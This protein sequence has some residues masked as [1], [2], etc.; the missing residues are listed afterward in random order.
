M[1]FK[2]FLLFLLKCIYVYGAHVFGSPW[3]PEEGAGVPGGA[4]NQAQVLQ[5]SSNH[6]EPLRHLSL[7][8]LFAE[9]TISE[10]S[11]GLILFDILL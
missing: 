2:I 5:K 9:A 4:K 1:V 6:S 3:R 10:L 7:H 8:H 11:D